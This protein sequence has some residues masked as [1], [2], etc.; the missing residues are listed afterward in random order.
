MRRA[1]PKFVL[2]VGA[3]I[4]APIVVDA[5]GQSYMSLVGEL[6]G[7]VESL[8]MLR[9]ICA[10]S[11]PETATQNAKAYEAWAKR[12]ADLLASVQIQRSR[13]DVR[14]A[15]QAAANPG[16]PKSTEDVVAIL[17]ERLATQLSLSSPE[18][19]KATCSKYPEFVL[20]SEKAR[21]D[22][23]LSLLKTVT[24]ADEVLTQRETQQ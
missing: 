10:S 18:V 5:A 2:L 15:K 12:H 20:S 24:H 22:E 3:L 19:R 16:A 14:L 6:V 9:D 8:R 11:T 4:C 1:A 7:S 13:A 23:I 17:R 21:T